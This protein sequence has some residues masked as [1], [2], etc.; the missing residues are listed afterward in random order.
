[1]RFSFAAVLFL[2]LGLALA[3]FAFAVAAVFPRD[4]RPEYALTMPAVLSASAFLSSLLIAFGLAE[5]FEQAE[6]EV[7]GVK[8]ARL[9][10]AAL[11]AASLVV[12]SGFALRLAT[13]CQTPVLAV[14]S[15]SM[16]PTFNV[17][18]LLFVVR[19]ENVSVGDVIAF[20][21]SQTI[22]VHRVVN[23]TAEGFRT[24]GD[25]YAQPDPWVVK[26]AEVYGKV[27]ASVPLLGYAFTLLSNPAFAMLL[28][29]LVLVVPILR[30]AKFKGQ[31]RNC[32][33]FRGRCRFGGF[34]P[35][36]CQV[37]ITAR[38]LRP[39]RSSRRPK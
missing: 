9:L 21:Q 8:V 18:D 23:A 16:A 33:F 32:P 12:A 28:F 39:Q 25:A 17:G 11:L 34:N 31:R 36:V 3:S 14:T 27:V 20:R 37:C 10:V 38:T 30:S 7:K 24:K 22:I 15:K 13:G 35:K 29:A 5:L 1:M 19:A 2:S 4:V 26:P 6:V